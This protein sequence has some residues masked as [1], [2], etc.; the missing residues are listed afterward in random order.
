[1]QATLR[2]SIATGAM[3][4]GSLGAMLVSQPAAA[5][6]N[7]GSGYGYAQPAVV[8]QPEF[9]GDQ[10]WEHRGRQF[11]RDERGPWISDLTATQG[12]R[13]R[14]RLSTRFGDHGSGVDLG[15]LVLRVDGQDVTHH[16]RVGGDDILYAEFMHP[17]RHMAELVVRDRAGNVSRRSWSFDVP[18]QGR[19]LGYYGR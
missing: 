16:A 5:Q 3:L 17:G 12:G 8:A 11:R 19:H 10:R 18:E 1:M 13:G 15:S 4:L 7:Y 9:R 14:T 6:Y 2:T